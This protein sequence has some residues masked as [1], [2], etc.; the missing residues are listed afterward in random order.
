MTTTTAP[1]RPSTTPDTV[2]VDI[3]WAKD[4]IG[5]PGIN[6]LKDLKGQKVGLEVTLV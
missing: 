2:L 4:H 6:S 3:T 5:K 1:V